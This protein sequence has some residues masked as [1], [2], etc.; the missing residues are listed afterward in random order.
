M[1]LAAR[2]SYRAAITT[3]NVER[4]DC[5]NLA[6]FDDDIRIAAYRL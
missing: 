3:V 1:E 5:V 4:V 6:A 2:D